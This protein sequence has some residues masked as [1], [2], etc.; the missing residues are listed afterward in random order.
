MDGRAPLQLANTFAGCVGDSVLWNLFSVPHR[1]TSEIILCRMNQQHSRVITGAGDILMQFAGQA[2][3][4]GI[5]RTTS[6]FSF[7]TEKMNDDIIKHLDSF[8]TPK[9]I[10]KSQMHSPADDYCLDDSD[11]FDEVE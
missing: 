7:A 3:I 2:T 11:Q 4:N 8:K 10:Q 5:I 6:L 1:E 9:D